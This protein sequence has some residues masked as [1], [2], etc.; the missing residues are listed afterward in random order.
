MKLLSLKWTGFIESDGLE[1]TK[2]AIFV[3]LSHSFIFHCAALIT[4]CLPNPPP[5]SAHREP[6][7]IFTKSQMTI[8]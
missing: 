4:G 1:Q 6:E 2:S 5:P 7:P 8:A 3:F